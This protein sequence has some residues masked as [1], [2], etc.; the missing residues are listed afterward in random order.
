MIR[1][2]WCADGHHKDCRIEFPSWNKSS[3]MIRCECECHAKGL[4]TGNSQ[5]KTEDKDSAGDGHTASGKSNSKSVSRKSNP[6]D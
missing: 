5:G 3:E 2:G 1:F 6:T 4:S